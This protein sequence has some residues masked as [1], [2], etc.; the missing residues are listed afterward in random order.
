MIA[1]ASAESGTDCSETHTK[2]LCVLPERNTEMKYPITDS[3]SLHLGGSG[4]ES[5]KNLAGVY[6]AESRPCCRTKRNYLSCLV[7]SHIVFTMQGY[8]AADTRIK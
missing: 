3:R 7:N 4:L 5:L 2:L 1:K 8:G 6:P